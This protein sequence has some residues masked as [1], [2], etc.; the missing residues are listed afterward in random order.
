MWFC[1]IALKYIC[2]VVC[3]S[4]YDFATIYLYISQ[5]IVCLWKFTILKLKFICSS[6]HYWSFKPCNCHYFQNSLASLFNQFSEFDKKK[7]IN[8][9]IVIYHSLLLLQYL[10]NDTEIFTPKL[11]NFEF[12]F[13]R[14]SFVTLANLLCINNATCCFVR[15][16]WSIP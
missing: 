9:H 16:K 8:N 15:T 10:T 5:I 12:I 6:N 3:N 4:C 2:K 13:V 11:F 7:F 1:I 14:I